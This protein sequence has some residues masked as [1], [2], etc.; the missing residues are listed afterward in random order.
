MDW[1]ASPDICTNYDHLANSSLLYLPLEK[2]G[3]WRTFSQF[4]QYSFLNYGI[5]F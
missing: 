4:D 2:H 1:A 3:V 5:D